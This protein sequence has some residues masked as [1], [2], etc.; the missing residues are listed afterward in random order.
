MNIIEVKDFNDDN[1]DI[2]ARLTEAQLKNTIGDGGLFI[3]ES[4]KVI[5][6]AL[7]KGYEAK[8]FL[9]ERKHIQTHTLRK[10]LDKESYKKKRFYK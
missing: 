8:S 9:M 10:I 3:A 4:P 2:Y 6:I 1:L 5:E 7:A